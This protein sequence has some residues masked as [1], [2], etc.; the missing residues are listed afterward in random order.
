MRIPK[1]GI[2]I[3]DS[4]IGGLT[5]LSQCQKVCKNELFYYY[6][7]HTRAPYG[8]K[9]EK[10]IRRYT[11]E[12]MRKFRR[13][14]VKAAVLACNTVTAVCVEELRKKFPFPIIGAEPAVY[15]AAKEGG[16]VYVLSTRATS[17]S[18]RFHSLC[19]K[20]ARLCPQSKIKSFSCDGLA[21]EIE[22]RI[23]GYVDF[24]KYLPPGKPDAVVL[25]CTHYIY[26]KK[27]VGEFYNC[28]IYDGNEGI[29]RRLKEILSQENNFG[30]KSKKN[31]V[32]QP[33]LT[34]CSKIVK[35]LN[36]CLRIFHVKRSKKEGKKG[37]DK[38]LFFLGKS[39][40]RMHLAYKQMF[41][42]K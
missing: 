19:Q 34:T 27:E 22:R 1:G 40:E 25:G 29:A 30:K 10:T 16:I 9:S 42:L 24:S 41:A 21:G 8:N 26:I 23:G 12:A 5:V 17:Q 38:K 3:F 18:A 32:L 31:R 36:K 39:R 28:P 20:T 35:K 2:G 7:D 11:F 4:G 15:L 14:K 6:G 13:L 33:R 37:T